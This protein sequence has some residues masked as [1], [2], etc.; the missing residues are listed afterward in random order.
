MFHS[1]VVPSPDSGQPAEQP[2]ACIDVPFVS[3]PSAKY[4]VSSC[5]VGTLTGEFEDD[6]GTSDGWDTDAEIESDGLA[7]L[8]GEAVAVP[9]V[10]DEPELWQPAVATI[11][12]TASATAGRSARVGKVKASPALAETDFACWTP[13]TYHSPQSAYAYFSARECVAR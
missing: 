3:P 11:S 9:L 2:D 4:T 5:A 12:V 13:E 6:A 1:E 8:A 7:V 10:A